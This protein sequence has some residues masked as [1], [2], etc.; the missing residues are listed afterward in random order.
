ME[1]GERLLRFGLSLVLGGAVGNIIDRVYLH[2]V[3]DF[4]DFGLGN[5][6]WPIFNFADIFVTT[7]V[8]LLFWGYSRSEAAGADKSTELA[9]VSTR[10]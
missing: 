9:G 10:E 8:F 5:L 1:P 4:F 2:E 6:R 7:G 3:V